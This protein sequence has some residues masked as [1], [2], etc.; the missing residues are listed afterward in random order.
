ML[1]YGVRRVAG[2]RYFGTAVPTA[3]P[4]RQR[5]VDCQAPRVVGGIDP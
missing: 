1:G 5:S 3:D 4:G 2:G